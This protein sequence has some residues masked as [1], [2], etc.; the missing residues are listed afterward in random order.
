MTTTRSQLA[1]G[2]N[3]EYA[4]A[5]ARAFGGAIIF[6][7]PLLMTME[8]WSLGAHASA[9]RLIT[10]ALVTYPLLVMLSHFL[11]F[12]ETFDVLDDAV[13]AFVA[14]A[15]GAIASAAVLLLLGEINR[16]VSV[17]EV[18]GKVTLQTG[19]GGIGALLAQTQFGMARQ[20]ERE[21]VRKAG[22]IGELFFMLVG[23]LFL[24]LNIA[25][26]D[27]VPTVAGKL[28][29]NQLIAIILVSLA[30]M[31]A[32]VYALEFS[33]Q[34]H[35]PRGTPEWS[36]FVRYTM[37]GYAIALLASSYILW[38]F[39]RFEDTGLFASLSM[40]VVLAFPAALGAAAAR[41]VL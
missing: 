41:L 13:D 8:M 32:F 36:V 38:V 37:T 23:A 27:E 16:E 14:I 19:A 7:L 30:I 3:R 31:H 25:P 5:V 1:R 21:R 18:V 11:G 24:S 39:G 35:V 34:A 2:P 28:H 17:R 33:G 26:T 29:P 15:I 20:K 12:E 22:Y 6:G 9:G 10:F 40:V 4:V